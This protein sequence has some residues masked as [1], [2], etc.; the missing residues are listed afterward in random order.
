MKR[1]LQ[2]L[3]TVPVALHGADTS[4]S[5]GGARARLLSDQAQKIQKTGRKLLNVRQLS[6]STF[7]FQPEL[8]DV[9]QK[10]LLF[11][12]HRLLSK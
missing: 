9:C 1:T 8:S 6:I 4:R 2:K 10:S 7:C 12:K 3:T 11:I 5:V